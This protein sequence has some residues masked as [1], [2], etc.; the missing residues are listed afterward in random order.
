MPTKAS[1]TSMLPMT[2]PTTPSWV[3]P[4]PQGRNSNSTMKV[5][6]PLPVVL[7]PEVIS[8]HQQTIPMTSVLPPRDTVISTPPPSSRPPLPLLP[9]ANSTSTQ[10]PLPT[11]PSSSLVLPGQNSPSPCLLLMATMVR[12]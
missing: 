11:P 12:Y 6:S 4:S 2:P 7:P 3:S 9:Q 8:S 10:L 1:S 5:T